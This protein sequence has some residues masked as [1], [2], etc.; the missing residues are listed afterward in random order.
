MP[1]N[2]LLQQLAS[3]AK[4]FHANTGIS[5]AL[6]AKAIG[7]ENGNYS[8]F[9]SG[10]R[11]IGAESTCL[12]LKFIGVPKREAI[13]R[14]SKAAPKAKVM[15]LQEQGRR[16][17]L[18]ND[19]WYPGTGGSGAGQ[20]PNDGRTIDDV[21]NADTESN[22]DQALI[23]TL[24]EVRGY[25]RKAIRSINQYIVQSKVNRDGSTPGTAQRFSTNRFLN[26]LMFDTDDDSS[27]AVKNLLSV[28][29][30][31][32]AATR[33]TVIAAILKAFPHST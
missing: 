3:R 13:A 27:D 1:D 29:G 23:D 19:G 18:A 30:S 33:K 6:M 8:A 9:L 4:L 16:M 31:L 25:H 7:L 22:W 10:K 20:D 24:R 15:L 21:P 17:R 11:G 12:L 14:F 5:Q 32:N 26:S 28:L 2:S